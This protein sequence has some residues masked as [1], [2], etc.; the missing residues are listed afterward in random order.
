MQ[1][2]TRCRMGGCGARVDSQKGLVGEPCE[3]DG[4]SATTTWAVLGDGRAVAVLCGAEADQVAAR[5]G[6]ARWRARRHVGSLAWPPGGPVADDAV[7][8]QDSKKGARCAAHPVLA[9]GA[10][11]GA[12]VSSF[13]AHPR[14]APPSTHHHLPPSRP[15]TAP[16]APRLLRGRVG[17]QTLSRQL[18]PPAATS[19]RAPGPATHGWS[20]GRRLV[21]DKP[22][23][24]RP[25]LVS[26]PP[27]P[28]PPGPGLRRGPVHGPR[29][30]RLS[31]RRIMAPRPDHV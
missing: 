13:P 1:D 17:S 6:G 24:P 16:R 28:S 31:C 18:E 12:S 7:G 14:S 5:L 29:A 27:S 8:G 21:H 3:C 4:T 19:V 15:A 25:H 10:R 30:R 23:S 11:F 20:N 26:P 22:S 9:G 2:R